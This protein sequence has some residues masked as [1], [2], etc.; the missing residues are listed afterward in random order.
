MSWYQGFGTWGACGNGQN[1]PTYVS[2]PPANTDYNGN[3]CAD[4]MA[5]ESPSGYLKMFPGPCSAG[6]PGSPVLYGALP[7]A[8]YDQ[9]FG[10]RGYTAD[11]CVDVGIRNYSGGTAP[12]SILPGA[13]PPS[14]NTAGF[15]SG[16][17]IG[18]YW[19]GFGLI[20]SPGDMSGDGCSDVVGR[21]G[22]QLLMYVGQ[23]DGAGNCSGAPLVSYI[24]LPLVGWEYFS[25]ITGAGDFTGDGCFDILGVYVPVANGQP[26][27]YAGDCNGGYSAGLGIGGG[28]NQFD[29]VW[30]PGDYDNDGCGDVLARKAID[31]TIWLYQG[32]CYQQTGLY[33]KTGVG[34]QIGN[35]WGSFANVF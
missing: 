32:G 24:T 10:A 13:T 15:G 11:G 17:T 35:G 29:R 2:K 9:L 26:L 23:V 30:S 22:T 7:I 19:N 6:Y 20:F 8:N 3:G 4:I 5:R 21:Y 25:F 28:W 34:V 31:G 16:F 14:C 18:S 12:L 33:W 1:S 27:V